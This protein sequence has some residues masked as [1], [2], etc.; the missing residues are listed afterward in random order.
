MVM[1][2]CAVCVCVCLYIE[3]TA[4]SNCDKMQPFCW[5][6]VVIG[7]LTPSRSLCVDS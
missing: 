6:T 3:V 5:T 4:Y 7:L 2:L 1:L